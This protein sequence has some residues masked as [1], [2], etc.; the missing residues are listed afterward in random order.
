MKNQ[1]IVSDMRKTLKSILSNEIEKLPETLESLEPKD[2]INVVLKLM[3]YVFPKVETVSPTDGEPFT[4]E[5]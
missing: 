2:R 5:W 3:S 4:A 1:I